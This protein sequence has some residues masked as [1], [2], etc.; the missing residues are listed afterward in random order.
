[1]ARDDA[2]QLQQWIVH[3]SDLMD[4]EIVPVV[5]SSDKREIVAPPRWRPGEESRM[6]ADDAIMTGR[7]PI[8]AARVLTMAHLPAIPRHSALALSEG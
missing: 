3:W 8:A 2:R 5:Q 1:M 7:R 6:T 4:F